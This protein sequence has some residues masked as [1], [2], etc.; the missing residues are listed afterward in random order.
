MEIYLSIDPEAGSP[1]SGCR[2]SQACPLALWMAALLLPH[3]LLSSGGLFC[4]SLG[5][6]VSPAYKDTSQIG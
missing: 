4:I 1:S 6:C 3:L 2:Q 5:L